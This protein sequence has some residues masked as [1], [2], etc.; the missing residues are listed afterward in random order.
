[1]QATGAEAFK[2]YE[3]RRNCNSAIS[4]TLASFQISVLQFQSLRI[5]YS[6]KASAEE[7]ATSSNY[8]FTQ[9]IKNIDDSLTI[10]GYIRSPRAIEA[11][12]RYTG[13]YQWHKSDLATFE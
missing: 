11:D 7:R 3:I 10:S 2:E 13:K 6:S 9:Q 12:N 4:N 8:R 1:M 5:S